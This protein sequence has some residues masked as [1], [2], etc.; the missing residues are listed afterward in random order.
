MKVGNWDMVSLTGN[1]KTRLTDPIKVS[2]II[3]YRDNQRVVLH[4]VEKINDDGTREVFIIKVSPKILN[5]DH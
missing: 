3:A 1:K 2:S 4:R 5:T